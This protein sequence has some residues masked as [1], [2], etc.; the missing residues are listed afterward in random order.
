MTL[1]PKQRRAVAALLTCG[2]VSAAAQAAG[3]NRGTLYRWLK[4]PAFQQALRE[5]EGE[6]LADLQRRLVSLGSDAA[7]VLAAA[8]QTSEETR[9][10]LRAA[11]VVLGRLLQLRELIDLERRVSEL[12]RRLSDGEVKA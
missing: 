4:Q 1:T 8:M 7:D 11:D 2:D 10:R 9:T 5:A 6:A 3:V 12:E